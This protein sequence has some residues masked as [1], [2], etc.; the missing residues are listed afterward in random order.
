MPA[1]IMAILSAIKSSSSD[2]YG[3]QG[4]GSQLGSLLSSLIGNVGSSNKVGSAYKNS[5]GNLRD[6]GYPSSMS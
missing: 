6:R 3:Q 4:S 2:V 1:L 5:R